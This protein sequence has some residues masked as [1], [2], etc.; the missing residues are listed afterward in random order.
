MTFEELLTK[1]KDAI[2]QRWVD[3]ALAMYS[4]DASAAF[5]REKDPFA[6]PVGHSLRVGTQAIFEALLDG[7][8]EEG[9][10]RGHLDGVIRVRAVQQV[11]ASGAVDFVFGLKQAV[12]TELGVKPGD[13]QFAPELAKL[14][15]QIDRIALM[16]F[17]VYVK[18]RDQVSELRINEVKRRVSWVLDKM[19]QRSPDA[20]LVQLDPE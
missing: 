3:D 6:N 18:C 5:R 2:L 7:M 9:E 15:G 16:A 19:G 12:R 10:I 17:D 14:D 8:T 20:E 1:K 4:K 13:A 11:S